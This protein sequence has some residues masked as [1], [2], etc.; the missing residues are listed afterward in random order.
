MIHLIRN[1]S[2]TKTLCG[3]P[4]GPDWSITTVIAMCSC[5]QCINMA[6]GWPRTI[7]LEVETKNKV[8][9]NS[10]EKAFLQAILEAFRD[11]ISCIDPEHNAK[12]EA[13]NNI[14]KKLQGVSP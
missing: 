3:Q 1:M 2:D 8:E 5:T 13:V 10:V 12:R 4:I 9:L 7:P 6:Y 14:L 11:N